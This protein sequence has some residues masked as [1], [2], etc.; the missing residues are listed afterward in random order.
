MKWANDTAGRTSGGDSNQQS[1]RSFDDRALCDSILFFEVL[2]SV[3]SKIVDWDKVHRKPASRDACL[4]NARY[5]ISVTRK[6]GA[7]AL[8]GSGGYCCMRSAPKSHVFI[9]VINYDAVSWSA[10]RITDR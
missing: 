1:I 6:L 8:V 3:D 2:Q 9:C 10:L 5:A 7:R 4:E